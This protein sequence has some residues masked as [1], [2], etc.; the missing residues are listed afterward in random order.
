MAKYILVEG[1]SAD[2]PSAAEGANVGA[3]GAEVTF[4]D[5][6][7]LFG[8]TYRGFRPETMPEGT[9]AAVCLALIGPCRAIVRF[10]PT[11]NATLVDIIYGGTG[12]D[13]HKNTDHGCVILYKKNTSDEWV[14]II[15]DKP[16][17]QECHQDHSI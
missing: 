9:T 7:Q 13:P 10:E 4:E 17:T 15:W 14:T 12:D 11:D 6:K 3:Y 16:G 2:Q 1:N 5:I 8:R